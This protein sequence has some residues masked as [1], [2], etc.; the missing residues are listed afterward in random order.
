MKNLFFVSVALCIF[1]GTSFTASAQPSLRFIDDILLKADNSISTGV[2]ESSNPI[3]SR[4]FLR[5]V[6]PVVFAGS[7]ATE[8]CGH[9]QFKFAQLLNRQ[10]ESLSNVRL[11]SFIDEWWHTRYRFGGTTK[12]G[13]DCS[14]F[15]GLLVGSVYGFNLPRTAREQFA[16]SE[17]VS[18]DQMSEGDLVFFNTHGGVSHVGFYLGNG[19]FVH[20]SVSSGVTIN[21]LS[22]SYYS[23]KF[24]GARRVNECSVTKN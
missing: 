8:M 14:A 12:K 10:V 19:F 4:S 13:I 20:S 7:L 17:K 1:S 21:N 11:F 23:A 5:T 9:I 2:S 15:V 6:N 18:A 22:E 24:I 3:P 16:S